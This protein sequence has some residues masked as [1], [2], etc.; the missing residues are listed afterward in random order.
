MVPDQLALVRLVLARHLAED[1]VAA[2]MESGVD[3]ASEQS[4]KPVSGAV[5]RGS[6]ASK[7]RVA[8]GSC[9]K[10]I[11]MQASGRSAPT[12]VRQH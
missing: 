2:A 5:C 10:V 11:P 9:T 1:P 7:K 12:Q 8:T 6:F 4:R 3:W